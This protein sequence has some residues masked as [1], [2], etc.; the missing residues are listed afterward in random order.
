MRHQVRSQKFNRTSNERKLLIRS[1]I[2]SLVVNGKLT[3]TK[4]KSDLLKR[5]VEKMLTYATRNERLINQRLMEW[6]PNKDLVLKLEKEI[7]PSLNGRKSGLTAL[8]KMGN[9]KGDNSRLVLISWVSKENEKTPKAAAETES[10]KTE[11]PK[12]VKKAVKKE[13]HE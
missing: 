8:T 4:T 7:I 9:R 10:P 6:L 11:N 1:L 3:T 5:N 12:K 2:T 13:N